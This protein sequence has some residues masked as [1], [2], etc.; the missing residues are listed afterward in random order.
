MERLPAT[1]FDEP[2]PYGQVSSG[3]GSRQLNEAHDSARVAALTSTSECMVMVMGLG[4][5]GRGK[6]GLGGGDFG[7]EKI[8]HT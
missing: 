6:V 4:N 7:Q 5:N 1:P 8:S 3:C 2:Q